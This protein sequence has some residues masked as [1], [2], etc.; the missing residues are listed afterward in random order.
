MF[1]ISEHFII[2]C[3]F[4][5]VCVHPAALC[6]DA[7]AVREV[8]RLAEA[9]EPGS[10]EYGDEAAQAK[11]ISYLDAVRTGLDDSASGGP[12]ID[13][14]PLCPFAAAGQCHYGNSCSYLHGD[15]CEIC[16]LQVLHPHDPE[17]R[18][19]H[20]KV[21]QGDAFMV[22]LLYMNLNMQSNLQICEFDIHAF[23]CS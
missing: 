16:R 23:G 7:R 21:I 20:E 5:C 2:L 8:P 3:V 18:R 1:Y 13:A 10:W 11:P 17:Q 14:P 22:L 4:V 19:A 9:L 15:V 12:F 6:P